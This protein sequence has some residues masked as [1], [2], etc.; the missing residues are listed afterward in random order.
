MDES[1]ASLQKKLEKTLHGMQW[2]PSSLFSCPQEDLNNINLGRYELLMEPMHDIALDLKNCCL[3]FELNEDYLVD[4]SFWCENVFGVEFFDVSPVKT[5][6]TIASFQV[7]HNQKRN[8]RCF[9]Y[10]DECLHSKCL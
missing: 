4:A 1:K 9:A 8:G 3:P 5:Q 2:V 7:I 10:L 6:K